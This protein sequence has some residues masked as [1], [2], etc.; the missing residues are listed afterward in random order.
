MSAGEYQVSSHEARAV[1]L[2]VAGGFLF[3]IA[4]GRIGD[5]ERLGLQT[6]H[7]QARITHAEAQRVGLGACCVADGQ[8]C[9]NTNEARCTTHEGRFLGAATRCLENARQCADAT[10]GCC[11]VDTACFNGFLSA[12]HCS[13]LGPT[14]TFCGGTSWH[15]S[16][17]SARGNSP[18]ITPF[19]MPT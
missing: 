11:R 15:R 10:H 19:M 13:Q 5:T 16:T 7:D 12:R 18:L 4:L 17:T 8:M 1:G 3:L 6:A 2:C 9:I 14:A